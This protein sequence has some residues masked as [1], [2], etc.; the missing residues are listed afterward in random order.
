MGYRTVVV[1]FN[2]QASTWQHDPELGRKI[3]HGMN[4]THDKEW[5]SPANLNYG[6]VVE[7]AH[8]DQQTLAVLDSYSFHPIA[9]SHWYA[10]EDDEAR[11]LKLLKEAA[12]KLGYRLTRKPKVKFDQVYVESLKA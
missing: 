3:A 10:R 5:D 6:R 8:A 4:S 2:D 9:H 7:C 11:N 12:D 1:L